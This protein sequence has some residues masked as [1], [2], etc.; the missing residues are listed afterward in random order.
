MTPDHDYI[1]NIKAAPKIEFII[2][3]QETAREFNNVK[4]RKN[5]DSFQIQLTLMIQPQNNLC[6]AW[7]TGLALDA[8]ASMRKVY[9]RRLTGV[10][11][12]KVASEY[13]NKGWLKKDNRDGHKVKLFTREAVDDALARGLVSAT[14]NTM[15][16]L[17]SEFIGYL[18]RNLDIDGETTLIYW[19]GGNG[20]EIEVYGNV[21]E[22]VYADLTIDGPEDIIFGKKTLLCPAVKF[23]V[24]R[25]AEYPLAMLVF[26]SDGHI[27]DLPAL[28]EYTT[29]LSAQIANNQ[30]NLVK[31]I[32]IGVGDNV[33]ENALLKLDGLSSETFINI[34]DHMIVN[35]FHEVMEIFSEV[36]RNT[37]I[38]AGA[39]TVYDAGGNVIKS[40]PNGL[41][42]T[43]VF[44]MPVSSP[45]FELQFSDQRIRQTVNVPKYI[46]GD[47]FDE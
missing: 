18:A 14:P 10:I 1:E 8:S 27:D 35:D 37:Q 45:W 15:D 24:D 20:D 42:A 17:G 4:V 23:M 25:F 32:L 38:V 11:P 30:H 34:W 43:V 21:Q 12:A 13:S 5:G 7:K 26:I 36:I 9:G 44:S 2:P 31:C 29:D 22:N 39:G 28:K 16:F 46:L 41:P 19:A 6:K 40:F 3:A 47:R 33:D